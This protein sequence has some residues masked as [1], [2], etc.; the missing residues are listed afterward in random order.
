M[1]IP[2]SRNAVL[3]WCSPLRIG[4]MPIRSLGD[5]VEHASP[6]SRTAM[7]HFCN[8]SFP[9]N[10]LP[11]FIAYCSTSISLT[12]SLSSS[13]IAPSISSASPIARSV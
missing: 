6:I 1:L 5:S 9:W 2:S 7:M 11:V 4:F 3:I 8:L 10:K 13:T 12:A